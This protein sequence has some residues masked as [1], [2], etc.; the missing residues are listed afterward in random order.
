MSILIIEHSDLTGSDRLGQRL[1]EDGH[2][3]NV[4]RVHL[5]E[6]L[7]E[8]LNE[9]DGVISCG[10]PQDPTSD[11]PWVEQELKLLHDADALE[12]PIFGLCLGCQLLAK[13]LGGDVS[14]SE[15][16]EIGWYDLNLTPVGRSDFILSGQPWIG[17]QLQWHHWQVKSLPEGATL[18]AS[19]ELCKIQAWTKGVNTYAVQFHPECTEKTI[20]LWIDDDAEQLQSANISPETIRADTD[21]YFADYER[22]TNRLFDAISQLLMPMRARFTRQRQ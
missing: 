12:L 3:L 1:L 2:L 20:E 6:K 11:E 4:V 14:K 15:K 5:G 16:P 22:L 10:G 7:P 18:L 9:I 19:S 8:D 21:K 13:A 17:P